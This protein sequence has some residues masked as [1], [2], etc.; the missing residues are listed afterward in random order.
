LPA[1]AS[2][3]AGISKPFKIIL[4]KILVIFLVDKLNDPYMVLFENSS[5]F[6]DHL[7]I[8]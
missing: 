2:D 1:E 7:Q 6:L 8:L 3:Q 5:Y 4:G